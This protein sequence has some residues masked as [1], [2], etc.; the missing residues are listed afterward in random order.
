MT[1]TP[2][3]GASSESQDATVNPVEALKAEFTKQF[4]DLKTSFSKELETLKQENETLKTQNNDLNRALVRS[5]VIPTT[6]PPKPKTE[7]ELYQEQ[8]NALAEKT[9]KRM[10]KS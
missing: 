10:C 8:I 4:E 7:E 5:T 3:T 2:E 9:L 1:Q 6:E